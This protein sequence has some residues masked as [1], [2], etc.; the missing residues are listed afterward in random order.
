M[1][2]KVRELFNSD[3]CVGLLLTVGYSSPL[4]TPALFIHLVFIEF[5]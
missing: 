1:L 3:L 4:L 5:S 2:K